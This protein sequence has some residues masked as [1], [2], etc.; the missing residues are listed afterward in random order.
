MTALIQPLDVLFN[1]QMKVIPPQ[2]NDR[3]MLDE[4]DINIRDLNNI[5]RF[6]SLNHN[7]LLSEIAH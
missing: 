2:V 3:V 4:L 7:Q 5:I 1:R 6:T